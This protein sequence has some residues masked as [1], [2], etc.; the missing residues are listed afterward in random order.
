MTKLKVRS[1]Q[2][3]SDEA[4]TKIYLYIPFRLIKICVH[5]KLEN[6]MW[7]MFWWIPFAALLVPYGGHVT[8][9]ATPA[10][11]R[12]VGKYGEFSASGNRLTQLDAGFKGPGP[13]MKSGPQWF[14]G[15]SAGV[16]TGCPAS[17]PVTTISKGLPTLSRTF[18]DRVSF[19]RPSHYNTK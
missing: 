15:P 8:T 13:I 7:R 10:A 16:P 3:T 9:H 1:P 14:D 6:V 19:Q 12:A 17:S 18:P 4:T 2:F 5:W 11:D